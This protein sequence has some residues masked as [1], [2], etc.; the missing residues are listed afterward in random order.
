MSEIIRIGQAAERLGLSKST[1]YHWASAKT[2]PHYKVGQS[3]LFDWDELQQWVRAHR[4]PAIGVEPLS[5]H[6]GATG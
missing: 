5:L 6:K 1:L 4:V 2:V 3:L